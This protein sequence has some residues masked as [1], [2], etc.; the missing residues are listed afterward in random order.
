[1]KLLD[2]GHLASSQ[3]CPFPCIPPVSL[4]DF[5]PFFSGP[6]RALLVFN[7]TPSCCILWWSMH[8]VLKTIALKE[9]LP[10]QYK[11]LMGLREVLKFNSNK[12]T[13]QM[14]QFYKFITWCF[15]W[16]NMFREPPCPSSGAYN[17]INSLWFYRWSVGGS[18]VVG[19]GLARPRPTMLP[20]TTFQGKTRG[21]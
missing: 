2:H 6:P 11:C 9:S 14:Q 10:W 17:C 20:T 18:S 7:Y 21:C 1:M 8:N 3:L 4:L 16:L 13:N 19:R 12:S 5:C 15:V